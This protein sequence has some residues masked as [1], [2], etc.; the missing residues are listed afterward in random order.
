MLQP[1]E[2]LKIALVLVLA[3]Q[4]ASKSAEGGGVDRAVVPCIV[5]TGARG[6]S[7]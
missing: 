7:S 5:L 3:S 4:L 1:S 2:L 6:R